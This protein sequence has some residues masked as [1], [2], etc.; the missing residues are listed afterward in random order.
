M[1]PGLNPFDPPYG[2]RSFAFSWGA[3]CRPLA[4]LTG[5][6]VSCFVPP[7]AWCACTPRRWATSPTLETPWCSGGKAGRDGSCW[8][9]AQL[10]QFRVQTATHRSLHSCTGQFCWWLALQ[11]HASLHGFPLLP[12]ASPQRG[13][14]QH[15][16]PPLLRDDC[17]TNAP[18][19]D[20]FSC[21]LHGFPCCSEDRGGTS[22]RHLSCCCTRLESFIASP[23]MQRGPRR[24]QHP[25]LLRD[26]PQEPGAAVPVR[27]GVGHILQ[28]HAAAVSKL[29]FCSI[30]CNQVERAVHPAVWT[31]GPRAPSTC[32]SSG[33]ACWLG[34]CRYPKRGMQLG[35]L[36]H[37]VHAWRAIGR[38][39]F[40][41]WPGG[42]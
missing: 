17:N 31:E 42:C 41:G 18:P 13:P 36:R 2:S 35:L 9:V 39:Q 4:L 32:R 23:P 3:P 27:A 28:A 12:L 7:R 37:A 26:D 16:H 20:G 38:Q 1:H 40:A 21:C 22:I 30:C 24:H 5:C 8:L 19:A 34:A 6:C 14:W 33:A 25:P 29:C 15:Q 11:I 10:A